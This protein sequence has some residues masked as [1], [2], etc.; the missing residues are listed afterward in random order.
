M[1][2]ANV[3]ETSQQVAN[4]SRRLAKIELL[5][6]LIRSAQPEEA[7]IVVSFLSGATRQGRIGT[8]YAAL[9]ER[10]APTAVQPGLTVLEVDR[11]LEALAAVKGSGSERR[12]RELLD[13]LF[14][15]ATQAEQSFLTRLMLGELRQGALEG[16]VVEAI[17]KATGVRSDRIRR[18][19]MMAGNAGKVGRAAIEGGDAALSQYDVQLFRPI[20]PM[21]AQSSET[22]EAAIEELGE[23]ALEFKFDGARVQVHRADDDVRIFTRSLNDVT[24]A[25]PEIVELARSLP[26]REF[27]LDGEVICLTPGG[28]PHPF[29]ITMRRFGRKLDVERLRAEL[30]LTPFWFDLVYLDGGSLVDEPQSRRFA[31]LSQLASATLAPHMVTAD[32]LRA[33]EFLRQALDRGHE[34][35]MAKSRNA[36]YAAG[37]R[38]QGW[39]KIK[40]AHTLDLV[41]LAAEWGNGRRQGWLSNLHLGARDPENGGYAMLGKTFKGM[42]D[43]MLEWQTKELLAREVSR[44]G[45]IVYVRPELV[46]EIAFN[47]VQHS[48]HYPGGMALRFARVKGYRPDKSAAEADTIDAVRAFLPPAV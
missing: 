4:A 27:I 10:T 1:L 29:Q 32:P 7:E 12:R 43:E 47:D 39:L 37:S 23:A 11:S 19:V 30:P 8:G 36:T 35:I 20:Q 34:G 6:A 33:D 18:A 21:L 26:A 22:V 9:R 28:A 24:P 44:D 46:V 5:A 38:G 41:I 14:C 48:P 3:V 42:T 45:H 13:T 40:K 2:L 15:R 31:A 16:I 17:A 25:A